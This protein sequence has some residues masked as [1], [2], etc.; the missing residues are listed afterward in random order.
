MQLHGVSAEVATG[1]II[2]SFVANYGLALISI[3]AWNL[4]KD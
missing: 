2:L 4:T 1:A 3:L